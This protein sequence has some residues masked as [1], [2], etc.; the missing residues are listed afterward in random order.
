MAAAAVAFEDWMEFVRGAHEPDEAPGGSIG[1]IG[2]IVPSVGVGGRPLVVPGPQCAL[3]PPRSL[4]SRRACDFLSPFSI[5]VEHQAN[6][7]AIAVPRHAVVR[8]HGYAMRRPT[9]LCTRCPHGECSHGWA[10][11]DP[12]D[13]VVL[14]VRLSRRTVRYGWF[15]R[16]EHS[17]QVLHKVPP[18]ICVLL[19]QML[20]ADAE[21]RGSSLVTRYPDMD[22]TWLQPGVGVGDAPHQS[23]LALAQRAYERE[24]EAVE[25]AV[26]KKRPRAPSPAPS[27]ACA[28]ACAPGGAC[29]VCLEERRSSARRCRSNRCQVLL[30]NE[31][32]AK[33]RGLC[34]ICDRGCM[35]A[36][37]LCVSCGRV[38]RLDA[39]GFPCRECSNAALCRACFRAYRTCDSCEA[40]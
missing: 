13:I 32:H 40:V 11:P 17:V 7:H 27:P 1:A 28:P 5:S 23:F 15:V 2:S 8:N 29:V 26:R 34:P 9:G 10:L 16:W 14:A 3:L 25:R 18:R 6:A 37:F 20:T 12:T 39:S 33:T 36:D 24:R 30:C 38:E 4:P 35:Q 22:T 19:N 31:C 21:L